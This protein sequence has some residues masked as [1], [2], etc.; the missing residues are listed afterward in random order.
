[1]AKVKIDVRRVC[2]LNLIRATPELCFFDEIVAAYAHDL[3]YADNIAFLRA[4]SDV[5]LGALSRSKQYHIHFY[6]LDSDLLLHIIDQFDAP[7]KIIAND[8]DLRARNTY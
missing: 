2:I 4:P 7:R 8:V 1:M 3:G 5:V 6:S